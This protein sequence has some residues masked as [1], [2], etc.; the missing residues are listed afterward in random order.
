[1]SAD[2]KP[3]LRRG[4]GMLS[5]R[6]ERTELYARL[7]KALPERLRALDPRPS[8]S[9]ITRERLALEEAIRVVDAE[10]PVPAAGDY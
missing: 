5:T 10:I 7:R 2:F 9:D 1:M 3:L 8:E 6:D 4:L